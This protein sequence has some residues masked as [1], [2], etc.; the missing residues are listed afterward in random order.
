[1]FPKNIGTGVANIPNIYNISKV[2][3]YKQPI[4]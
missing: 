1:M 4:F 2:S 3:V